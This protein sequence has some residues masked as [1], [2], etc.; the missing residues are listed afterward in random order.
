MNNPYLCKVCN[1]EYPDP[2]RDSFC[3]DT[4]RRI[5]RK[6]LPVSKICIP[7]LFE[8][9]TLDNYIGE[10]EWL[11]PWLEMPSGY[12]LIA[13]PISGNGKTHLAIA[14][15]KNLWI[16]KLYSCR[17]QSVVELLKQEYASF[18][19]SNQI[20]SSVAKACKRIGVLVLDD[21]GA[22]NI[23]DFSKSL[24]YEIVDYRYARALPTVVTT[25]LGSDDLKK[26]YGD[27]LASRLFSGIVAVTNSEER[28]LKKMKFIQ[29]A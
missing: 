11:K 19:P 15:L 8:E 21:L 3:S 13:S 16:E 17:F 29:L 23:T 22:E 5:F 20:N 2:S 10:T 18:N 14:I 6:S 27:R 1:S 9:S 12:V 26:R 24:L 4:C 28:R 7:N 25:N